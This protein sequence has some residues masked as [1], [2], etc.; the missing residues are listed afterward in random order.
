MRVSVRRVL[1]LLATVGLAVAALVLLS[2]RA[3]TIELAS[4]VSDGMV[5]QRD[6]RVTIAGRARPGWPVMV[7]GSWGDAT[8]T[9]TDDGGHWRATLRTRGAGGP[10]HL[11]VW[12]GDTKV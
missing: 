4:R 3:K 10:Y 9:R 7:S 8:V 12:S 2:R 5:L 1:I 6:T 11:L